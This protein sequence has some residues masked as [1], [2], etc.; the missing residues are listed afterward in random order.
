MGIPLNPTPTNSSPFHKLKQR[1]EGYKEKESRMVMKAGC[2]LLIFL[3]VVVVV[4][5]TT[6]EGMPGGWHP[7]KDLSD[8][9]VVEIA[10]FAVAEHD[11]RS[12]AKLRLTGV[13]KGESQV[14]AGENYRLVL[15]T[16]DGNSYQAVVWDKPW[17]HFRKLLSF[18]PLH[19]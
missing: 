12:G 1:I 15:A 7:I 2:L 14:V 8:P 17:V 5:T 9:Y 19:A 6:T 13:V 16:S 11:K 3:S 4:S 18:D 10:N